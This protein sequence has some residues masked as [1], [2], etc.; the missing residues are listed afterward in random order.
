ME[1]T[2]QTEILPFIPTNF[3]EHEAK[4]SLFL[5]SCGKATETGPH[6]FS[7]YICMTVHCMYVYI[8]LCCD[9]IKCL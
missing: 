9:A 5:E 6:L 2:A 4:I 3:D 7:S 1:M 8:F